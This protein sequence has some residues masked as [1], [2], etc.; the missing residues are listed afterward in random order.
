MIYDIAM[1]WVAA[2]RSKRWKQTQGTLKDEHGNCCLGVLC[3][4]LNKRY[5]LRVYDGK[6]E[7]DGSTATLPHD[8]RQRAQIKTG[9]AAPF[10]R[11][12][13]DGATFYSLAD[14]NDGGCTFEQ[15]A[16]WIEEHW[17]EL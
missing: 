11:V 7:F 12:T 17:E 15:I 10:R 16:D 2:L 1:Q 5:V 4:V 13:I 9:E 3:E 6:Y 14:A 8:V